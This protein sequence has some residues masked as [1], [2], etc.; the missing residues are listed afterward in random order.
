M[1]AL[2]YQGKQVPG[3]SEM[4]NQTKHVKAQINMLLEKGFTDKSEIYTWIVLNSKV[5]R[6]TVR[7]I[8][9]AMLQEMIVKAEILNQKVKTKLN[10]IF[11]ANC[12]KKIGKGIVKKDP[13]GF[14]PFG[15]YCQK[16]WEKHADV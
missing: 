8:A 2:Y 11:C 10:E 4:M 3:A 1:T 12:G 13:K 16:C 6:P 15:V 9:N 5:P 7:R 14:N